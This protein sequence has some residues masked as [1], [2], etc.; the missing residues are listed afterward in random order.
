M[1]VIYPYKSAPFD[2]ELRFSLRSL[3]NV[4]HERVIV[5]G[6]RPKITNGSVTHIRVD[7]IPVRY[8]SSMENILAACEAS[9][10]EDVV[11]MH[12]DIF[13]LRP[14]RF[15]HEH[16]GS[17]E[18]YLKTG[19]ATGGYRA[20]VERTRDILLAE[21]VANP[22]FFGMHTPTVYD[23]RNMVDLIKTYRASSVLLRTLYHNL[24]PQPSNL[25]RDVKRFVWSGAEPHDAIFSTSD[26]AAADARFRIWIANRFPERSPYECGGRCLILG[27]GASVWDDLER[28][29]SEFD[30]VIASPEAAEHWPGQ[31]LAVAKDND[32]AEFLANNYGFD[33]PT[34][35]GKEV[36]T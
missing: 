33:N 7:P 1:D 29:W 31:I 36:V 25:A 35:C 27:H 15:V 20:V 14:W 8:Q 6:D 22:L 26:M 4:P 2:F 34:W 5:A 16:R 3:V 32:H 24:F 19:A 10:A 12:D 13:V 28:N 11:V 18:Q 9:S 21:G 23:R 30:A 17:I